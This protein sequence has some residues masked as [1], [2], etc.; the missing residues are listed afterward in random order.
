MFSLGN[1]ATLL[2]VVVILFA[3]RH[4]DLKS[5]SLGKTRRYAERIA[6]RMSE[7][8]DQ[9][10]VAHHD[11]AIELQVN[12]KTGKELLR[13]VREVEG[14]LGER[15]Q[16]LAAYNDRILAHAQAVSSLEERTA[17]AVAE[18]SQVQAECAA[19][20]EIKEQIAEIRTAADTLERRTA[21]ISL[22]ADGLDERIR[23]VLEQGTQLQQ[24]DRNLARTGEL[25]VEVAQK[26]SELRNRSRHVDALHD[27]LLGL[28]Q[29]VARLQPGVAEMR[30]SVAHLQHQVETVAAGADRAGQAL[31][32]LDKIDAQ[33]A[34]AEERAQRLQ[35]AREWLARAETRL[36]EISHSAHDQ[37]RLLE[38]LLKAERDLPDEPSGAEQLGKRSM[39][40]KLA[41]QGWT[42]PEIARATHLS[43]GEVELTLEVTAS[44][45]PH[46]PGNGAA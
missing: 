32:T 45:S 28:E 34:D 44:S 39:V 25:S 11:L 36:T 10:A 9:K 20:S 17:D 23:E 14:N 3:Y 2:L 7:S 19:L 43:R 22:S 13:R 18:L 21:A 29:T 24:L 33:M 16:E 1:L 38:T 12:L 4:F 46:V 15:T 30:D 41:G 5:R 26:M 8:I 40:V 27:D 37:L 35:V 6:K 31:D 42:V